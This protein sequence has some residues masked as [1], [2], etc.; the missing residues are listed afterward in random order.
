MSKVKIDNILNNYL[1]TAGTIH[2]VLRP[3]T[4]LKKTR[5]KLYYAL[6]FPAL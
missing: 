5:L 2:H 3:F 1:K 4:T 6:A